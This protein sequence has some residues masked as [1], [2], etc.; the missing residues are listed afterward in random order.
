[1]QVP[2]EWKSGTLVPHHKKKDKKVGDNY[3]G[4][5]L[6]NVPGKVLALTLLQQLHTIIE[7]QL[8]DTQCGFRKR[9]STVDQ[10]WVTRQVLEKAAKYQTPVYLCFVD[11]AKAYDS[12][13]RTALVAI[14][15]LYRVPH[16]LVDII[17]ELYTGTGLYVRTE[18]GVSEDFQ[19]KTGVRQGCVLSPLLFNCVMDRILRE[20][21][22][23]LGGNL[24]TEYTS[25]GGL[26]LYYLDKTTHSLCLHSKCAIY[27]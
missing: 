7:P 6:L 19:V 2:S 11:L 17:Q 4:I 25:A 13:D 12:V 23:T 9:C 24:N 20:A 3:R 26:F 15:K 10:I 1:M 8:M 14:P 5:S 16:Q 18:D 22:E 21:T 27:R